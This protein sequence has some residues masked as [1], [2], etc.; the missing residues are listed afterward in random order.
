MES[1]D[2]DGLSAGAC[3]FSRGACEAHRPRDAEMTGEPP[4]NLAADVAAGDRLPL[5]ND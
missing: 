1:P 3:E 2:H 5:S 4:S